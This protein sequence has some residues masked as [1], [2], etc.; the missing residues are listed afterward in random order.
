L[1][2]ETIA[3]LLRVTRNPLFVAKLPI[4]VWGQAIMPFSMTF[5]IP[6][7][8]LIERLAWNVFLRCQRREFCLGLI[9][10]FRV[11]VGLRGG[12]REGAENFG[13]EILREVRDRVEARLIWKLFNDRGIREFCRR[14][15]STKIVR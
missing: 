3:D 8:A 5:S 9:A 2:H 6:A 11:C 15:S 14:I 13:E 12:I 10:A 4:H 1:V 7:V